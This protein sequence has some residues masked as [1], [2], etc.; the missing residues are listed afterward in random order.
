MH[1]LLFNLCIRVVVKYETLSSLY[2][3]RQQGRAK[4]L[5]D[6]AETYRES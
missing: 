6:I 5:R 3:M 2:E 4:Y 1:G